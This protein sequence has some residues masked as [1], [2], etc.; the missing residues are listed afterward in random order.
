MTVGIVMLAHSDLD[1]VEQIARHWVAGGCPVVIH[2]DKK[3]PKDAVAAFRDSL[4]DVADIRLSK[5][6]KCEWGMWGLVA[7]T[8]DASELMLSEF[9]QVRHVFLSSGACVPLR[10][11]QELVDYLDANPD[12]DFIE[13][14]TTSEVSWAVDG[15]E[16]ERFTLRFPFS[17]RTQRR[18]FDRYVEFQRKLGIKRKVPAGLTPHIGSQWWCLTRQTLSAILQDPLRASYDRYFR[19]VWIPD[20]SY[21]QTLAR[22][23]SRKIQSR[24]LTL[25]KFDFQ[26]KPHIF[27]DDHLQ[28]LR[29]SDCFVARKIWPRA[30]RLFDAFLRTPESALKQAEPQPSKIDR[31]F[32]RA[33]DRRT[34]GRPGLSMQSRF[35]NESWENGLTAH[36][37]T[38]LEGFD[39]LFEDFQP[40]LQR[41]VTSTVH[42]HLF[43]K[44]RAEFAGGETTYRGGLSDNAVLRDY[45]PHAFLKNLMWNTRGQHQCFFMG[46]G[47]VMDDIHWELVKDANANLFVI[48]GA[49]LIQHFRSNQNFAD[50]RADAALR[51]K[52]EREHLTALKSPFVKATHKVWTMAEFLEAPVE[53]LRIVLDALEP[54]LG[55]GLTDTPKLTDLTGFGTFVRTLKNQG[56]HPYL[57]GDFDEGYDQP[58]QNAETRKPYLVR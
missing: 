26:G 42:G 47:D 8:Q 37:Y 53:N 50:I 9:P 38:V 58:R 22:I 6:H 18:L 23:S 7:A 33:T 16:K 2:L 52:L 36:A 55:Q 27:Y 51:Q 56:M 54:G 21:F 5:R 12:T 40:W 25:S 17:W 13:S 41:Q 46:P 31:L 30:D 49:W 20:E 19:R 45:N 4:S 34:R 28:L 39:D 1:R 32:S 43:A 3:V 11:V 10:P 48:S 57:L 35:P 14:A 29:R 24:S 44:D 15:L